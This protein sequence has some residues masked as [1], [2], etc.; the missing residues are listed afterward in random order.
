MHAHWF[1]SSGEQARLTTS[2][3]LLFRK[4]KQDSEPNIAPTRNFSRLNHEP[5]PP[6]PTN[7]WLTEDFVSVGLLCVF[8]S[9]LSSVVLQLSFAE[10]FLGGYHILTKYTTSTV[11]PPW[12]IEIG[13]KTM[14]DKFGAINH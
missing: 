9:S 5:L 12:G 14:V 10:C 13:H 6:P 4:Q 2:T 3:L 7:I 8:V 11:Y 1:V